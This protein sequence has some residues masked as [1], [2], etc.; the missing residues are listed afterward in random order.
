MSAS[1]Q[2]VFEQRDP[3]HGLA[4]RDMFNRIAPTYDL[5]NRLLSGGIER[6]GET[7]YAAF[8][9]RNETVAVKVVSTALAAAS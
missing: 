1:P 6:E 5:L 9:L 3:S 2:P 7:L 8:P 4:V